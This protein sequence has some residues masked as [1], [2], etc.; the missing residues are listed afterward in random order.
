MKDFPHIIHI[1][2][3]GGVITSVHECDQAALEEAGDAGIVE[4]WVVIGSK[5]SSLIRMDLYPAEATVLYKDK[6]VSGSGVVEASDG[7]LRTGAANVVYRIRT[8]EG[9]E[10]MLGSDI[11]G[12]VPEDALLSD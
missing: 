7:D 3:I 4:S 11:L 1:T 12:S 10:Y 5:S 2:T 6:R 9:I 8:A